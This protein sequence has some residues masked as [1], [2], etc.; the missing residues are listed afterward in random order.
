LT[1]FDVEWA[2]KIVDLCQVNIANIICAVIVADLTACPVETLYLDCLTR[3][4][5]CNTRNYKISDLSIGGINWRGHTIWM[6]SIVEMGLFRGG[7]VKGHGL[8]CTDLARHC[9]DE[10]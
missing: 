5:G 7:F 9:I 4:N 2:G 10:I 1:A 3:F 8:S 6:P